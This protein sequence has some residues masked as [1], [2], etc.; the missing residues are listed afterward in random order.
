MANGSDHWR[1]DDIDV[2]RLAHRPGDRGEP[3]AR[4]VLASAL[5]IDDPQSLPI[6]REDRGRPRLDAP[7]S[8]LDTGWSHSGDQLLV[9]LG[10]E[11]QLGVDLERLRPRPRAMLLAERFYHPQELR[12][13]LSLPPERQQPAF[14]R[15]WCAKE[16]VLKAHGHGISFGLER[17]W[18]G[19]DEGRLRVLE[20]PPELG[21]AEDWRLREWQPL[22]DYLAALAWHPRRK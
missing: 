17:F 15:L 20:S 9:A 2:W 11:Q 19:E 7:L 21:R 10:G 5:G 18:I 16:A 22:P 4:V 1:F 12:W 6:R 3:Q 13:L 8:H 14:V